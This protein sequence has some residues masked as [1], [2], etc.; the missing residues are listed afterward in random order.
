MSLLPQAVR[1]YF[2]RRREAQALKARTLRERQSLFAMLVGELLVWI[3]D[4]PGWEVTF[5]EGSVNPLRREF[6]H[7][8]NSLHRSRLALDMNLFVDGEWIADGSH[9]VWSAIG[10]QWESMHELARWGGRF[11]DAN[12]I[13][14]TWQGRA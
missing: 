1:D 10:M 7:M 11:R 8:R 6:F 5:G 3:Y 4:H 13:S 9:E 2:A 14:V 12:H